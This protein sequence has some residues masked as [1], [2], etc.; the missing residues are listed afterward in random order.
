MIANGSRQTPAGRLHRVRSACS[1]SGGD[2]PGNE[3]RTSA[4]GV[5]AVEVQ[6]ADPMNGTNDVQPDQVA[7]G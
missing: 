5:D 3:D 1:E 6:L 4:A 7:Q 2:L